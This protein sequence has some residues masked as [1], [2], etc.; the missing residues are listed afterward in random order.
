MQPRMVM[1]VSSFIVLPAFRGRRRRSPF[2]LLRAIPSL[3]TKS[4]QRSGRFDR[5]RGRI[6]SSFRSETRSLAVRELWFRPCVVTMAFSSDIPSWVRCFVC[7]RARAR[8][9]ASRYNLK[10]E[11]SERA[12]APCK[13]VHAQARHSG[14]GFAVAGQG[15]KSP[16]RTAWGGA[17]SAVSLRP[18]GVYGAFER[19]YGPHHGAALHAHR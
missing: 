18:R 16:S 14:I 12:L 19:Q 5:E 17:G 7:G 4:S 13:T 15:R 8:S 6:R 3:T 1:N 10:S 2:S 9:Q 11:A